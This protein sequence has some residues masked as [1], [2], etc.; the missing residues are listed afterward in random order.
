MMIFLS[1]SKHIV[2]KEKIK[3]IEFFNNRQQNNILHE[4][5]LCRTREDLC[6]VVLVVSN[7]ENNFQLI[8]S[9]DIQ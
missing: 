7:Q 2:I 4:L 5:N 6:D 9:W 1:R 3:G 8:I